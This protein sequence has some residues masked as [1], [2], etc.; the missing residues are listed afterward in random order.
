MVFATRLMSCRTEFSRSLVPGLPWKY[1]LVT[2]LVAV[3]DQPLGTS[4]PSWRKIVVPFSFPI[5]AVRFSHSTMSN[6]EVLPSVKRR[7][8]TSPFPAMDWSVRVA[9][10][11]ALPCS[12]DF[13]VAIRPSALGC[14]RHRGDPSILLPLLGPCWVPA[15][16]SLRAERR[17]HFGKSEA[18]LRIENRESARFLIAKCKK[19]S[20]ASSCRRLHGSSSTAHLG[21]AGVTFF[22]L[23]L[24]GYVVSKL[25]IPPESESNQLGRYHVSPQSAKRSINF[26]QIPVKGKTLNVVDVF[27]PMSICSGHVPCP[28]FHPQA[29]ICPTSGVH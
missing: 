13:T 22:C 2:M 4:T 5:S 24:G 10:S 16:S 1:L 3:C 28:H 14:P 26:C 7:S 9:V 29:H 15:G 18:S 20:L 12:A 23:V 8:N 21:T 19:P 17:L 27:V 25:V 11:I 6:A